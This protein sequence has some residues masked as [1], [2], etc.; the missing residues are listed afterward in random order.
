MPKMEKG[1]PPENKRSRKPAHPVKREVSQE[2]K[3]FAESTMNELL[4]W[5]GYDKVDLQDAEASDTRNFSSRARR[6][7]LSVLKENSDPKSSAVESKVSSSS[8]VSAKNGL[9]E[10][11]CFPLSPSSFSSF[12]HTKD[13]HSTHVVVPLIKPPTVEEQQNIQIVCVWCQKEGL[14]RYSLIMGSELKS[15]CSEKC[16]A[17]CRRAYFKRNKVRDEDQHSDQSPLSPGQ[18]AETPPR[19]ML[20]MS[21]NT[22]V[23]DWCKHVRHTKYLDFGAGEERL[24][25]CSTKCLNQYKMDIFYREARAAL[26][27]TSADSSPSHLDKESQPATGESQTL[28]TPESWDNPSLEGERKTPSPKEAP[29]PVMSSAASVLS[30]SLSTLVKAPV[31]GQHQKEQEILGSS[32]L[33]N[34]QPAPC[35]AVDQPRVL[36]DP[37]SLFRPPLHAQGL[38]STIHQPPH[39]P[40]SSPV[41]RP[42]HPSPQLQAPPIISL[43]PPRPFHPYIGSVLPFAPMYPHTVPPLVPS[44]GLPCTQPTVLVPYPIIVPL[45]VPVPIPIPILLNSGVS[46][47]ASVIRNCE[48]KG[49]RGPET[50]LIISGDLVKEKM[51]EHTEINHHSLVEHRIKTE[52]SPSPPD[53]CSFPFS[54]L[55]LHSPSAHLELIASPPL[56][57]AHVAEDRDEG[58]KR[59]V[60]QRVVHRHPLKQEPEGA[61][62]GLVQREAEEGP[63]WSTLEGEDDSI[64]KK[65][66]NHSTG[67]LA[68]T[69]VHSSALAHVS[70]PTQALTTSFVLRKA[71]NP[72]SSNMA[73]VVT[74]TVSMLLSNTVVKPVSVPSS[75]SSASLPSFQATSVTTDRP[76]T[77][78]ENRTN[79]GQIQVP[80]NPEPEKKICERGDVKENFSEGQES[81][82]K[83]S[84]PEEQTDCQT[85]QSE[86]SRSEPSEG[87]TL[88]TDEEHTYARCIP[89]KLREK[90]VHTITLTAARTLSHTIV[91]TW[92][93]SSHAVPYNIEHS[94]VRQ[95]AEPAFKRRCLSIRDQKSE[96]QTCTLTKCLW[97]EH[98]RVQ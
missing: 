56:S 27:T 1:R 96:A 90:G 88:A 74:P 61:Q 91:H 94:N 68:L 97:N 75:F 11:T 16:F 36:Q 31:P 22:R 38:H 76:N 48:E 30:S 65:S 70:L 24:Q 58:R 83:C 8:T 89:P 78:S 17:M 42:L 34:G 54:S 84:C 21:S 49:K 6:H 63:G 59:Q 93:R 33:H 15:F 40:T 50:T 60:I 35:L 77:P 29:T 53:S 46:G 52:E 13:L 3:S 26:T 12:P 69:T 86:D 37:P 7:H 43:P 71:L 5:Y 57:A 45:P 41:Q 4:G 55:T 92:N 14:K 20:K 18:I 47:H 79:S 32:Q 9:R 64:A 25:F 87:D 51:P 39:N 10:S 23:C 95:D 44:L 85:D 66:P 80:P 82:L 98:A 67:T 19:L 2:M 72:Y 73:S 81:N 62:V 28:L